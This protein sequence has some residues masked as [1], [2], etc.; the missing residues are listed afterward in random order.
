MKRVL[1]REGWKFKIILDS[2]RGSP[3]NFL[4]KL[5]K[6]RDDRVYNPKSP[7]NISG[8][9][10]SDKT[11][12]SKC[13][14][15]H[16][17]KCIVETGN[18]FSCGKEGH[19]VRYCPNLKGKDYSGGKPQVSGCNVVAQRKNHFY[20]L[21]SRGEQENSLDVVTGML[22]VF[23]IHIIALLDLGDTFRMLLLW[24]LESLIFFP[25]Y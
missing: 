9:S 10:P 23:S 15:K 18:C 5:P 20:A 22:Q 16:S 1:Q 14:K 17:G 8:K 7:K 12:C 19:K 6:A 4:H 13:G 3:I 11:T 24:Y 21:R 25:I 2:R